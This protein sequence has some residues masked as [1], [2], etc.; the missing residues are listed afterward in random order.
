MLAPFQLAFAPVALIASAAGAGGSMTFNPIP[1]DPGASDLNSTG[2]DTAAALARVLQERD[3]LK[4]RVCGRATAQDLAAAL[5]EKAPPPPGPERDQALEKLG[6]KLEALASERTAETRRALI[7]Q[8]G[9][10]PWQV[11]ECRSAFD[12]DDTGAPRVEITF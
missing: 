9:A 2:R 1:F 7:E 10:K 8:S 12:P 6:G 11:G 4:L 3:K 5:G